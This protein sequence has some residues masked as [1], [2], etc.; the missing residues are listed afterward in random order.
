MASS[1]SSSHSSSSSSRRSNLNIHKIREFELE[2]VD[3]VFSIKYS[4]NFNYILLLTQ[5]TLNG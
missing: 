2:K 1:H 5:G 4:H 3:Q